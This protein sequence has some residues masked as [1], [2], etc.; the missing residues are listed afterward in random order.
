MFTFSNNST[1]TSTS[2]ATSFEASQQEPVFQTGVGCLRPFLT[3]VGRRAPRTLEMKAEHEKTRVPV[4]RKG[5]ALRDLRATI[6]AT[7]RTKGG[8]FHERVDDWKMAA[9]KNKAVKKVVAFAE[10]QSRKVMCIRFKEN[11][12]TKFWTMQ[13]HLD[14]KNALAGWYRMGDEFRSQE[15][16]KKEKKERK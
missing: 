6:K 5:G 2:A 11:E 4:T 14:F 3:K 15:K 1:S 10:K 9:K 8:D 13:E 12:N 16:G 7:L